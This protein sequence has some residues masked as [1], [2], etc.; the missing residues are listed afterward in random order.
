MD[1]A[2]QKDLLGD[3]DVSHQDVYQALVVFSQLSEVIQ[4]QMHQKISETV[5]RTG[6][7]V[8]YDSS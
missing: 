8:F 7:L 2:S 3:F 5:G 4:L 1:S 6:A